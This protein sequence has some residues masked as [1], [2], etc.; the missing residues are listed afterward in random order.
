MHFGFGIQTSLYSNILPP[1]KMGDLK[2]KFEKRHRSSMNANGHPTCKRD[3]GKVKKTATQLT[4]K[5]GGVP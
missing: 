3:D 1:S 2:K 5:A 4:T